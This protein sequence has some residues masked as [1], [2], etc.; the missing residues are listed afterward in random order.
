MGIQR[1]YTV[2]V[3]RLL[4]HPGQGLLTTSLPNALLCECPGHLETPK[5]SLRH[6]NSADLNCTW[7]CTYCILWLF[8]LFATSQRHIS[9]MYMMLL[10]IRIW[11]SGGPAQL[12]V[13]RFCYVQALWFPPRHDFCMKVSPP[14]YTHTHTSTAS[15]E[16]VVYQYDMQ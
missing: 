5:R 2:P 3:P 9:P 16:H 14:W 12:F 10:W 13:L 7:M 11:A 15:L 1:L 6:P 4:K 8:E